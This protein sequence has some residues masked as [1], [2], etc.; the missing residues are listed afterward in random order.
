MDLINEVLNIAIPPFTFLSLCLLLPPFQ[1]L[2]FCLSMLYSIFTED[3]TGKVVIIT[4][5]SSG[6]G[7]QMAYEYARRGACVVVAARRQN[8]LREVA[9]RCLEL[10]SPDSLAITADVSIIDDCKRIVDSTITHFERLDHLVCNAGITSISMLEDYDDITITRSVMVNFSLLWI[11]FGPD[12]LI[13]LA[14]PGFIESEM[15]KGKHLAREGLMNVD[16]NLRDVQVSAFPIESGERCAKSII[17]S[18]CRGERHVT[19]PTWY[20]VS[21]WCKAFWPELIEWLFWVFYLPR[22]GDSPTTSLS[23]RLMDFP[24]LRALVYPSSVYSP[25]VKTK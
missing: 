18:A 7:E 15:M 22:F 6:I 14:T 13:T 24:G 16:V 3:V 25:G 10:G 1:F 19:E 12:I 2:K 5:A 23:K 9:N 20:K 17:N 21:R 4:G 8:S 11:E